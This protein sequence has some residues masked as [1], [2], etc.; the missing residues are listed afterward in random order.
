MA[1]DADMGDW[2]MEEMGNDASTYGAFDG[3]INPASMNTN[4]DFNDKSMEND[5][6]FESAASSPSPFGIGPVDMDSP[7]MPTIKHDTPRKTSPP[8]K[9]KINTNHHKA[10]SVS[11]CPGKS[12]F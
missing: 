4:F 3:T 1:D 7:E 12:D 6:D 8:M 11:S 5:F 2:K 9:K 10:A